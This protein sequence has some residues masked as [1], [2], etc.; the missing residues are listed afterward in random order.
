MAYG[1]PTLQRR[2]KNTTQQGQY[3]APPLERPGISPT[4]VGNTGAFK[5][6]ASAKPGGWLGMSNP[7]LAESLQGANNPPGQPKPP[8]SQGGGSGGKGG[9]KK[10][11]I[12]KYLNSDE[13]YM[14]AIRDLRANFEAFKT[15]NLTNRG[16]L[17]QD[18]ADTNARLGQEQDQQKRKM[19]EEY[20]ARGMFGSGVYGQE[21]TDFN[22]GF[23]QQFTDAST[24]NQRNLAQL[25][26][27]L[28]S[29]RRLMQQQK[30]D[31]RLAALRRRAALLG[32]F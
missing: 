7:N 15:Q 11:H 12:E 21:L 17:A 22:E 1:V 24:S 9:K 4:V 23:L 29:A 31:A 13:D 28:S 3:T 26:S 16:N 14:N 6:P 2:M 30:A 18:F 19:Q 5:A 20:A 8:A 32:E 27:D 10:N 25:V